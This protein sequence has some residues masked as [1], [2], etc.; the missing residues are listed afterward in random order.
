MKVKNESVAIDLVRKISTEKNLAVLDFMQDGDILET[1]SETDF[2][3]LQA[4]AEIEHLNE[5]HSRFTN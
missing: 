3:V 4:V 5:I 2:D 1:L